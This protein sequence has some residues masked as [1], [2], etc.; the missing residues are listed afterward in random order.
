MVELYKN[1]AEM[2]LDAQSNNET[3]SCE[4]SIYYSKRDGLTDSRGVPVE[5]L[6]T[7]ESWMKMMWQ[8]Q[9]REAMT[10]EQAEDKFGIRIID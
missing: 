10:K 5:P 1:T 9:E 2:Y 4:D 8:K 7:L 6:L 3:Y